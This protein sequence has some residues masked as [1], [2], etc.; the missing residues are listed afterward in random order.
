MTYEEVAPHLNKITRLKLKN[1]KRKVGWIY[2]DT[3]HMLG[4][5]PYKEVH[6]LNVPQG[7]R[8]I[9]SV[10]DVDPIALKPYSIRILLEDILH[11]RSGK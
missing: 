7:K 10:K 3:Y 2:Y 1:N 8:L 6:C 5:E 11:I 4:S 9:Q